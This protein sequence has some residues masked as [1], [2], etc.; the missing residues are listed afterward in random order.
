M[1]KGKGVSNGIN[2]GNVVLLKK[3][4]L[5]V[6]EFKVDDRQA[7]LKFFQTTFE[8]VVEETKQIAEKSSG[9]E[10]DIM[11]AYLAILQDPTLIVET[12]NMIQNEGYNAGYATKVGFNTI[13]QMFKAMDDSYMAERSAD[14]EDMKNRI[15]AKIVK[16]ESVNLSHLPENTIMVAR[17]LTTSDTAKLDLKNIA[18]IITE[19][20]GKNSH[21]SIM[22]RTHEIPSI[23]GIENATQILRDGDFIGIYVDGDQ[24]EV[25]LN[26]TEEELSKLKQLKDEI[27]HEKEALYDFKE[28]ESITKDGHRVELVANIGVP[29][30]ANLAVE[31]AA[32]GIG[33]FRS[34][35][36]YMDSE[37]VPTEE[38]QFES[39]KVVV[40]K[41]Q[42]KPVIIRTLDVGG[43]KEIK[44]IS[45]EKEA[46]PFL[47][48]RAIRICL[49][50]VALFKTQLRA[51]LRASHFGNLAIMLPMIS[52]IDELRAAKRIIKDVEN[53]L[54][55]KGI[56]YKR[57]IKVGIMIEIPAA[58]L[59]A[60]H[61]A[62][63][64]DFFSIGTNDLIQ[65]TTAVERGN[66]KI[67]KLYT[68]YHPGVIKLIKFAID[69]AHK[70]G[71][72]CGMCGEAAGDSYYIPLLLGLGLDEFS[73]NPSKILKARKSVC[74]ANFEEC[75]KLAEEIL[76]MASATEVEKR[77]KEYGNTK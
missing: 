75:K 39:Y 74:E 30:D 77:L 53:E 49:D 18:G 10:K 11:E 35:F 24:G 72:F 3:E 28:R 31:N 12:Q 13:I 68:K 69:G 51:L 55:Q 4:E 63:E 15:I 33:L 50:D 23:I 43:D 36:L 70:N 32:E 29:Q 37:T 17:E 45:L 34:E 76:S 1:I 62:K 14:I 47:G 16:K 38:E 9:T 41:M 5:K 20:G 26:P 8:Q 58:A 73:M 66:E 71:I 54:D 2:F 42:G 19:I 64:C 6:E 59:I 7:E 52:S 21:V 61:L 65:Y 27:M 56:P 46:N 40:E 25:Y 22:A 60:D 57:D 67:A 48:Y 44:S